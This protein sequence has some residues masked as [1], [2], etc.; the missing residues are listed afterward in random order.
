MQVTE[1]QALHNQ[2][3]L[4]DWIAFRRFL[5]CSFLQEKTVRTDRGQPL[6][7][8]SV[9]G[10]RDAFALDTTCHPTSS[11]SLPAISSIG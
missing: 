5:S 2:R 3:N 10:W 1:P 11:A 4:L 9:I 8:P 7:D 6:P